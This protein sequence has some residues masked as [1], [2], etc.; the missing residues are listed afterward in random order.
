MLVAI[1]THQYYLLADRELKDEFTP[2]SYF[3]S[4]LKEFLE[5]NIAMKILLTPLNTVLHV[6]LTGLQLVKK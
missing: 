5:R 1:K 6:K 4:F 3:V 2:I